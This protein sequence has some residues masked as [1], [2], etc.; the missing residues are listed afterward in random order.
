MFLIRDVHLTL[1]DGEQET[2]RER[3]VVIDVRRYDVPQA[4]F[5]PQREHPPGKKVQRD[6]DAGAGH[7]ELVLDLPVRIER[8][9][10]HR[11]PTGPPYAEV[12]NHHLGDV[13][14]EERDAVAPL[15]TEGNERA[16]ETVRETV[17]LPE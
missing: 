11:R 4:G 3:Q 9:D 10:R 2:D 16:G 15:H 13:G 5:R 7:V 17:Q 8:V 6:Q 14:H 1:H 12:R